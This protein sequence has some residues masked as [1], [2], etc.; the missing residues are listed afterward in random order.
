MNGP[1]LP[2]IRE[3][4]G[5]AVRI[6]VAQTVWYQNFPSDLPMNQP[7]RQRRPSLRMLLFPRKCLNFFGGDLQDYRSAGHLQEL[8]ISLYLARF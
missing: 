1:K 7:S 8:G 5:C 6:G 3:V 2:F 4:D